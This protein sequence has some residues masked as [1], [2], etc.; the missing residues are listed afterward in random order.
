MFELTPDGDFRFKYINDLHGEEKK[1]L[2]F[3]LD[4]IN[5]D[6]WNYTDSELE[7]MK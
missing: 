5:K 2:E 6:R 3:A 1:F 4:V 7:R